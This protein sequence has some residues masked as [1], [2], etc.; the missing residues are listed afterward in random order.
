MQW[1]KV[2]AGHPWSQASCVL[3]RKDTNNKASGLVILEII[4]SLQMRDFSLAFVLEE[5]VQGPLGPA[6]ELEGGRGRSL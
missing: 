2:V 3:G 5:L 6:V 1:L 4:P